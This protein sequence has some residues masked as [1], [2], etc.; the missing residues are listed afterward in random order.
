MSFNSVNTNRQAVF[1]L[2]S[3][4]QTNSEL[5]FTQKRVSTGYRVADA[6]DDGGA[7]AVAQAV[8]SD[9]AGITAVG[10]QLGGTRGILSTTF[11]SL[12]VV[13]DTMKQIRATLTRLADGAVTGGSRT[14][15]QEQYTL[16][17]D[18]MS[19][20]IDDAQYNGRT[21]LSTDAGVG[22][23][24]IVSIRNETG[25]SFTI[26][27]V[28]GA[29]LKLTSVAPAS[30]TAAAAFL[31][32]STG[33]FDIADA[34]ISSALNKFGAQMQYVENQTVYNSKK[35]DAMNDGLGALVDADL[36][37]E[38]SLL[39]A[40]QTRQQLGVQTLSLANQGPQVLLSLFR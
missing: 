25:G 19:K 22:G 5:G 36:A 31:Q 39:Q 14:S 15:Y 8:R 20:F 27:A 33:L 38:S 9:V 29:D 10:E 16:L 26:E 23:G 34:A 2:Q 6:R 3:L 1:A 7:F 12:S 18:Q 35:T 21:L 28:N 37:K 32:P 4:N 11:A 17:V 30:A 24:N 13:S 40:L